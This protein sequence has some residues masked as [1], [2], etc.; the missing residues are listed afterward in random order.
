MSANLQSR[1]HPCDTAERQGGPATEVGSA[2]SAVA[3]SIAGMMRPSAFTFLRLTCQRVSI[4]GKRSLPQMS[5]RLPFATDFQAAAIG[6]IVVLALAIEAQSHR[7]QETISPMSGKRK[8]GRRKRARP[9][10]T[11]AIMKGDRNGCSSGS[12]RRRGAWSV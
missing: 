12:S 11:H 4:C 6:A 1:P 5:A 8:G 7:R 9:V 3:S 2:S 10:G